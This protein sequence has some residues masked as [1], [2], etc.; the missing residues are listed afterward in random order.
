MNIVLNRIIIDKLKAS[1]KKTYF[2]NISSSK[3]VLDTFMDKYLDNIDDLN[4]DNYLKIEDLYSLRLKDNNEFIGIILIVED[5]GDE[6]EVGYAIGSSYWNKGYATE[7]LNGF[8]D[9]LFN[10]RNKKRIIASY[11]D[12]NEASKKVM[13]KNGMKF[14]YIDEEGLVYLNKKRKLIY[15]SIDK[16]DFENEE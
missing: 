8:I 1:D 5:K 13:E 16:E 3:M 12:G 2:D 9:Y 11:F 6:V 7:S 14:A 4:F 15:Y 10:Q